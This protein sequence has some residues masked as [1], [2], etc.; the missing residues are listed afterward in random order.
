MEELE[1]QPKKERKQ[2]IWVEKYR[3][4]KL[5]DYL[6]NDTIKETFKAF[7]ANQ[8]FGH[9]LLCGKQGSGKTSIAKM[10]V[11]AIN[12][13]HIYINAS[14]ERG[15][16]V[17]RDKIKGFASSSGFKPLKIIILDECLD[18][19]TLVTV[20][21]SGELI[22]TEIKNLKDETDLVKSYNV[23]SGKVEWRPFTLLDKGLQDVY[24]MELEN[25]EVIVCTDSHKWYV[26]GENNKPVKM[27]LK[28]IMTKNILEILTV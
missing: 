11:K 5:E 2:H 12:C 23:E 3:P 4:T 28:D 22:Q 21:R 18:E 17:I 25:G 10:L 9:L 1:F 15:I 8:D 6:G 20:L 24:E 13:D 14:D 26:K 19:N 7:V 16:D 27:K